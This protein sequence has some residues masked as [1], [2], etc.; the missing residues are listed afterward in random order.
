[1]TARHRWRAAKAAVG[2]VLVLACA[3]GCRGESAPPRAPGAA[4]AEFFPLVKSAH[5]VYKL[6][7]VVTST[8]IE[9]VAKGETEV[10]GLPNTVFVMDERTIGQSFGMAPVGP[11]AY[12]TADGFLSR[13]SGLDY[14]KADH[15][16]MLGMEDPTRVIPLGAT[17]GSEW[18]HETRLM[19]QPE[20]GGGLI[21]WTG[22]TK[23]ADPV[24]VPAG[25]FTDVILVETEY[26]DPSIDADA[27]LIS[28]QDWYGRGVGLL[29]SV[30]LNAHEGGKRMAEQTLESYEFPP[31]EA[32]AQ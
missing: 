21:K 26:W 14:T 15:L 22:R 29:R 31:L 2:V 12:V 7:L 1:M 13:Y 11:T 19:Q 6:D 23:R 24:T 27:P 10:E 16:K 30:T 5:W 4:S 25:T 3:L 17:P 9:V 8:E 18:T 20:G 28:Y 32:R